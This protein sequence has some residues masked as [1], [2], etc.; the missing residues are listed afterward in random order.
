[1]YTYFLISL[2]PMLF[3]PRQLDVSGE[4]R[5][6]KDS[7]DSKHKISVTFEGH[8]VDAVEVDFQVTSEPWMEMKCEDGAIIKLRPTIVKV[9]RLNIYDP[10]TGEPTYLVQSHNQLQTRGIP[11]EIRR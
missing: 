1:M 2:K 4:I 9:L 7:S 3:F 11:K 6:T 10:I 8:K 5:M